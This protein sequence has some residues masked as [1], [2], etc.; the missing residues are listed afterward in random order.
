MNGRIATVLVV[1]GLVGLVVV[2]CGHGTKRDVVVDADGSFGRVQRGA[3]HLKLAFHATDDPATAVGFEVNGVFDLAAP[4]ADLPASDTTTT[5]VALPDA[6]PVHFVST[7]K[8]A[9]V[10]RGDTG[11]Q[12]GPA[13]LEPLRVQPADR[14]ATPHGARSLG[15][16]MVDP[17]VQAPTSIDG[18]QVDRVVGRFA[19]AAG[20]ND[21]VAFATELGAAPDAALRMTNTD[22]PTVNSA[23]RSSQIEVLVGRDDHLLRSVSARV[24]LG[25]SKAGTNAQG[26]LLHALNRFGRVTLTVDL[27][28]DHPNAPVTIA[29]PAHVVPISELRSG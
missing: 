3:V 29:A 22:E 5:N 11:Y 24:E 12:L 6:A 2:G 9:Y 26:A 14:S 18:E 17:V 19:P 4:V 7:G 16:W 28:I 27:R 1:V 15:P 20:V 10:V 21:L 23:I 25:E 8:A 13:E